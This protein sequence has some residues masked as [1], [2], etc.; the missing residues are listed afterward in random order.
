MIRARCCLTI[1]FFSLITLTGW[2][3]MTQMPEWYRFSAVLKQPPQVNRP[4]TVIATLT[5]L[6]GDIID[7][8]VALNIPPRWTPASPTAVLDRLAAGT[9]RTFVFELQPSGPLPNGSIGCSFNAVVPKEGIIKSIKASSQQEFDAMANVVRNRPERGQGYADIAFALFPEEGF[10]P[11]GADM[12]L[13][14]EDRLTPSGMLRGPVLFRD[15][16]LSPF[17]AQTD[18]EMYEKVEALMAADKKAAASIQ[19]S[20]VDLGKKR[21]D[22]LAGLY[23]LAMEA[24]LKKE[25]AEPRKW[26]DKIDAEFSRE[27]RGLPEYMRIAAGNLRAVC[28]WAKGEKKMAEDVFRAT[29]YL[30]R[31]LP[32]QRYTLRNLGLFQHERGD[33]AGA[34]EM[35]RLALDFKPAYLL[36]SE[37]YELLKKEK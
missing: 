28:H 8:H 30:N 34:R 4:V 9:S 16:L 26:L 2:G 15:T 20:G 37:E 21:L 24:F 32:L 13:M 29:F 17:Q 10:Y 3:A 31:K 11:L 33:K 12:W 22:Y 7:I 6:A 18:V 19:A 35:M 1:L 36:L 5:A 14:Y 27:P 23:V 25:Y